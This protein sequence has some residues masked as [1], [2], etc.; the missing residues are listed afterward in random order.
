ME[1]ELV[2][3]RM[4]V[5]VYGANGVRGG[6]VVRRLLARGHAVRAVARDPGASRW[7]GT[8]GVEVVAADLAD[9]SSVE[10][11]SDGIDAVFLQLPL[12]YDRGL[13]EAYVRNAVGAAAA[14]GARR[15][16]HQGNSRPPAEATDVA[17]FEIDRAAA[18]IVLG[19]GVP[20]TVLRPTVYMDNLLGP[21]TAPGIV[22]DG[23]LAYPIPATTPTA[24]LSADD[25][26]ALVVAALEREEPV[27]ETLDVGGPEAL[28]GDEA[29][30]RLGQ[31]L[32]RP[33]RYLALPIDAFEDG[34]R[35]AL[36]PETGS[37]VAATYRWDADHGDGRR[38]VVDP[39]PLVA[40][41]GAPLTPL[42][43][44][45]SAQAW[46]APRDAQVAPVG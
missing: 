14:A 26:A 21:W 7:L 9:R 44:W 23:V 42:A 20:A 16:V 24:W 15:L 34:L 43:E 11:A 31:A 37:A 12:V 45:A 27:R 8:P 1:Q 40:L 18:Q 4:R 36:G 6:A 5:L 2:Q 10:R 41:L 39:A 46:P 28:T 22:N 35:A 3:D 25:A 19:G 38:N 30:E 17:G 32:G 13:A 33:V 29:A